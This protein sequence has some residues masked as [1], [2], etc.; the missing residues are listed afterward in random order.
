MWNRLRYRL[1]ILKGIMYG[2]SYATW[3]MCRYGITKAN[4]II[5]AE[6]TAQCRLNRNRF[7]K[8]KENFNSN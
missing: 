5:D 2:T 7:N 4:I 1:W 8:I 3:L 6:L